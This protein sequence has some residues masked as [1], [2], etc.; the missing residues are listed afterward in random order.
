MNRRMFLA[1]FS[2]VTLAG[3]THGNGQAGQNV[4]DDNLTLVVDDSSVQVVAS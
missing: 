2:A 4:V 1:L 3:W